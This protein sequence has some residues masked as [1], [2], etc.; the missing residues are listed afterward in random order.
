MSDLSEPINREQIKEKGVSVVNV[1]KDE[2]GLD[3]PMEAVPLPS[4]GLIY[5]HPS[6]ANKETLDIT[7]MTARE[8][9][10]LMSKALIKNGTVLDVLLK[11][12]LH[13]KTIPIRDL[14]AGDKGAL[15]I[16]LRIT[17]YGSNYKTGIVC[18]SCDEKSDFEFDLSQLPIKRLNLEPVEENRNAFHI[19]LPYSKKNVI[20]K[21]KDGHD[22]H[23]EM[24]TSKNKKRAKIT[25]ETSIT[26]TLAQA[27][28]EVEGISDKNKIRMFVNKLPV[29][30][31]LALRNFLKEIE[32][33]IEMR[34]YFACPHCSEES[35]VDIPMSLSFFWPNRWI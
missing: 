15:L 8:E 34:Q 1:A 13:D 2:F 23:E 19:Q 32:P 33:T 9:D 21:L 27:I 17:G 14:T 20:V 35:E 18:P 10:I 26:D 6:L 16:A 12:C 24:V 4:R 25:A 31:S 3:I 29:R 28:L 7:P 30:D 11:S 22:E 5:T